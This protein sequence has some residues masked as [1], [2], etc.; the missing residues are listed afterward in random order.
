MTVTREEMDRLIAEHFAYE[1]TDDVDGV[2]STL[3]D[4]AEHD[5]V[6]NPAGPSVGRDVIRGFY[7]HLFAE[8]KQEGYSPSRRYY[9][10][11]FVV[12]EVIWKGRMQ[13][14]IVGLPDREGPV[15]YRLLHILEFRDGKISRE[16]V[17]LDTNTIRQQLA[18]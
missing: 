15:E 14:T 17:W 13:G 10:D 9:G 7:E 5:V 3:T 18:G 1:A 16:N 8:L 4:D 12:D 2:L 11:D 6:G